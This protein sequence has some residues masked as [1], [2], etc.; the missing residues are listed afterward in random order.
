MK[1][2]ITKLLLENKSYNYI[3]Q[4]VGCSKAT[5]SY[6]AK[7]LGLG[8]PFNIHKRE[9]DWNLIQEELDIGKSQRSLIKKY[10]VNNARWANAIK[11]GFIKTYKNT[12][13]LEDLTVDGKKI[14]NQAL[15]NL[16]LKQKILDYKCYACGIS[17]WNNKPLSLQLE[18]K[19]GRK[20]DSRIEN[21]ELLC[22]NCHSQTET[23]GSRNWKYQKLLRDGQIG[24]VV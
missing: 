20:L 8:K 7:R 1:E 6:H 5:I 15:K 13:K 11:Q 10:Q 16:L 12:L 19:N 24:K 3:K 14:A 2:Q 4:Q 17:E 9:H 21:L 23:F 18:H 22:P